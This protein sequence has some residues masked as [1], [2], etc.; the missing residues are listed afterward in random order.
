M[1]LMLASGVWWRPRSIAWQLAIVALA[2]FAILSWT[3]GYNY[4]SNRYLSVWYALAT[5]A[6]VCALWEY[7]GR[8]ALW[9]RGA[10]FGVAGASAFAAPLLSVN[11]R[12]ADL[13]AAVRDR[14]HF[15]TRNYPVPG[16]AR[17]QLRDLRRTHPT[18]RVYFV[19]SD[20][21]LVLPILEDR[22]LDAIIVT[23]TNFLSQL[24]A[25]RVKAGDFVIEDNASSA[26]R[27]I[28]IRQVYAPDIFAK[29][30]IRTMVIYQV[31]R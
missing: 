21:S 25:G 26:A 7:R 10:F 28:P 31:A 27:L 18:Q 4:W 16:V 23:R 11:R 12:P 24:A 2:G 14:D 17:D 20:A 8:A 5:V 29:G 3:T 1:A 15:E 30:D 13:V 19:V 9:L 6:S 22:Q